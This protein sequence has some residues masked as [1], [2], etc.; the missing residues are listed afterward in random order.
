MRL[1]KFGH[2]CVRIEHAGQVV[3][4]DPGGFTERE[5][6]AGATAVLVTH[7]HADH[8]DVGHLGATDAPIYTIEA[9]RA[10]IAGSASDG[11]ADVVDRV[12]LVTPEQSFDV[13]VPV[14][15]VGEQHAVIHPD[16]P[17]ITNTGFLLDIGGVRVYHPG[18]AFTLPDGRVDVLLLPAQAPWSKISEVVDFA[19]AVGAPTVLAIHDGL[20]NGA[21]LGVVGA[22]LGKLLDATEQSFV[23]VEPGTDVAT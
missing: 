13:G 6:M 3:V 1:T 17:R 22:N 10:A 14:V 21:G 23:R 2:A 11:A 9:V 7:E 4:V 16:I 18:D 20:L 12:Q 15:A 19:R 5:A 8:L